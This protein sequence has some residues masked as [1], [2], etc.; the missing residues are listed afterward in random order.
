MTPEEIDA[1][2]AG[3]ELDALVAE[4]VMGWT[5]SPRDYGSRLVWV[6]HP[7]NIV[8][9]WKGRRSFQ[10]ST[11][12]AAAWEVLE[13]HQFSL[14]RIP[15]GWVAGRFDFNSPA[16]DFAFGDAAPTAPLAICRAALKAVSA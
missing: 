11:D 6:T 4:R 5:R 2:P 1:L 10:P 12:I 9:F 13:K 8:R 14:I 15:D 3:R 7:E 16:W